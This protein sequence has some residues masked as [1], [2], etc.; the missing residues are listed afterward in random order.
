MPFRFVI[1]NITFEKQAKRQPNNW[2]NIQLSNLTKLPY[3]NLW[4]GNDEAINLTRRHLASHLMPRDWRPIP[5]R[6]TAWIRF[7]SFF[8]FT[9][10]FFSF[11]CF[12]QVQHLC[13]FQS[14]QIASVV[15]QN[16]LIQTT[17]ETTQYGL[18]FFYKQS[19]AILIL[20]CFCCSW[21]KNSMPPLAWMFIARFSY[22]YLIEHRTM[23]LKYTHTNTLA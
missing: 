1:W 19:C 7:W 14:Y 20:C 21:W 9:V 6:F 16:L 5:A 17:A 12:C 10:F 18:A 22:M 8:R 23:T 4:N 13:F 3:T 11:Y 15:N 2:E